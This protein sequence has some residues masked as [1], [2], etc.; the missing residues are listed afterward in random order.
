MRNDWLLDLQPVRETARPYYRKSI[1]SFQ[2][3]LLADVVS[4]PQAGRPKTAG[5]AQHGQLGNDLD[6]RESVS[7]FLIT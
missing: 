6:R 4:Q 3:C 7:L 2:P 5:T 1:R